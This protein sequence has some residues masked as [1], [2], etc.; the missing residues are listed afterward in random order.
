M[1]VYVLSSNGN[2]SET[3]ALRFHLYG[4]AADVERTEYTVGFLV[5]ECDRLADEY[6]AEHP[7]A[8][9]RDVWSYRVGFSMGVLG[10]LD[11]LVRQAAPDK[12]AAAFAVVLAG[13]EAREAKGEE[14]ARRKTEEAG[15]LIQK[16]RGQQAVTAAA[17][18][19]LA[20][21]SEVSV[22]K[23]LGARDQ[24]RQAEGAL[25]LTA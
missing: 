2:N 23:G 25:Y 15:K 19:G 14:L 11:E 13:A 22:S 8:R 9:R 24:A 20:D 5:A 10:R 6:K 7:S 3:G 17:H 16:G 12:P 4:N 21:G 18:D 1:G